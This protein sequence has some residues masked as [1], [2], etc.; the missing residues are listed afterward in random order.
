MDGEHHASA[1]VGKEEEC[2]C[3]DADADRK[4]RRRTQIR[5]DLDGTV[6]HAGHNII[7][8]SQHTVDASYMALTADLLARD[9]IRRARQARRTGSRVS[10]DR[11]REW[12]RRCNLP[13]PDRL[14]CRCEHDDH[15]PPSSAAAAVSTVVAVLDSG[16][17]LSP[18]RDRAA[19]SVRRRIVHLRIRR[20]P[21]SR[22][23]PSPPDRPHDCVYGVILELIWVPRFWNDFGRNFGINLNFIKGCVDVGTGGGRLTWMKKEL[24]IQN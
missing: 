15:L 14:R 19:V 13:A 3:G 6:A 5:C 17:L 9:G 4:L 7:L 21:R 24:L 23:V 22:F 8:R 10:T 20:G 16:D 18:T 2:A 12:R 11:R 1:E